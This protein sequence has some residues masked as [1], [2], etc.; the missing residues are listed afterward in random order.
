VGSKAPFGHYLLTPCTTPVHTQP[1][2]RS[3]ELPGAHPDQSVTRALLDDAT[4]STDHGRI[5]CPD[6]GQ[7]ALRNHAGRPARR[8]PA[9]TPDR[10]ER[11]FLTGRSGHLLV[12]AGTAPAASPGTD[13]SPPST[14]HQLATVWPPPSP[15][16]RCGQVGTVAVEVATLRSAT[17]RYGR[18]PRSPDVPS[19]AGVRRPLWG[20]W[21]HA[22]TRSRCTRRTALGPLGPARSVVLWGF[23]GLWGPVR[24]GEVPR[25]PTR[26]L[27]ATPPGT[28]LPHRRGIRA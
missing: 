1:A 5:R 22:V 16:G 28:R 26:P 21:G 19:R 14:P 2:Q 17:V 27:W 20:P 23:W 8:T 13:H 18:T 15:R 12:R 9:R 4:R 3:L 7:Q 24:S 11:G 10:R 25:D 6:D